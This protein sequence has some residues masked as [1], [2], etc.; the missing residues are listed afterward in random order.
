LSY[1]ILKRDKTGGKRT[2]DA[3]RIIGCDD[4]IL[5]SELVQIERVPSQ[6]WIGAVKA[7]AASYELDKQRDGTLDDTLRLCKQ[8]LVL[9]SRWSTLGE[10]RAGR[11]T[12]TLGA[13]EEVCTRCCERA[14]VDRE[15][16]AAF[17]VEA[18]V[19]KWAERWKS[20][21][22]GYWRRSGW[23]VAWLRKDNGADGREVEVR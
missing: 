6:L 10:K 2:H 15:R 12:L 20:L 9:S 16:G 11:S 1:P 8:G 18:R 14:A 19:H 5:Q 17:D 23:R 3:C 21:R 13:S 4:D 22:G 7:F